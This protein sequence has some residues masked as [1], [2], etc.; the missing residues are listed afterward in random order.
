M[1][2][3]LNLLHEEFA[4]QRQRQRDPLKL[5]MFIL[6]G[7][8]AI[9]VAFYMWKAYQTLEIKNR[10]S[11]VEREWAKAEPRVTEAHKRAT[12]LSATINTTSVLDSM[13][14]GRFLWAPL[15]QKLAS[16]VAPNAQITSLEGS[17]ADESKL[18]TLTV[19]GMA[20]GREP[21][22]AAE[23]LRQLLAEQLGKSY[24][25]VKVDF[26]ALEDLETTVTIA[27]ATLPVAHYI[28]GVTLNPLSPEA[29][30]AASVPAPRRPKK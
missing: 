20:A 4:Q 28:L 2:L 17:V 9:M 22:G 16:C 24:P 8:G 13:I 7:L 10:L 30:K 14:D 18:V 25:S 6:A 1:A 29:A 15:L 3:Q 11:G 12:E 27:G 21:R 23:E 5:G 19:D 26:K